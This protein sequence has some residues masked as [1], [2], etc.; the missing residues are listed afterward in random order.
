M[1][2]FG[3]WRLAFGVRRYPF[4][5]SSK[6]GTDLLRWATGRTSLWLDCG[7]T[8]Q[9]DAMRETRNAKRETPNAV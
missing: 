7:L 8:F 9:V 6:C 3:V 2:A 1:K 4:R 5:V